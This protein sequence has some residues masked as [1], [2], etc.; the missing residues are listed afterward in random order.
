M[1]I[2]AVKPE[3]VAGTLILVPLINVPSF[4]RI[5]PHV[6]PTDNK[7]MNRYYP[8]DPNGTQTDRASS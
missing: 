4:E 5:T 7:S 3:E 2:D 1:L 8:G 6:N